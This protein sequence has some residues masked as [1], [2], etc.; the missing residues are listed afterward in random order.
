MAAQ[1]AAPSVPAPPLVPPADVLLMGALPAWLLVHTVQVEPFEGEGPF[2]RSSSTGQQSRLQG[3]RVPSADSGRGPSTYSK[4]PGNSCPTKRAPWSAQGRGEFR[5]AVRQH[6]E[7]TW[8]HDDGRQAKYLEQPMTDERA[9][10][11]ELIA[12]EIRRSLR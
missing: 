7:L 10:I 11:L 9:T 8:K 5:Y 12:T 4:P 3:R 2:G 6:E 1:Q